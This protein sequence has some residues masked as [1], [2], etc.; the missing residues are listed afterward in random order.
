MR[1]DRLVILASRHGIGVVLS[2]GLMVGMG[3]FGSRMLDMMTNQV[4]ALTQAIMNQTALIIAHDERAK[5]YIV[6]SDLRE[7]QLQTVLDDLD[8]LLARGKG[9]LLR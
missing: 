4:T 5:S 8:R 6:N 9:T 1:I 7:R 2:I 3:Y